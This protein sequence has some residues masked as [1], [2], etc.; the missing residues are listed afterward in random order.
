MDLR[1]VHFLPFPSPTESWIDSGIESAV[2]RMQTVIELGRVI[3]DRNT[4]PI[5]YPLKRVVV[6]METEDALKD[7]EVHGPSSVV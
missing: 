5:K 7:V 2:A 6:V 1:S 3:R 4:M